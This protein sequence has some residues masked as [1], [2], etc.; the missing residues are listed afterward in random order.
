MIIYMKYIKAFNNNSDR[1]TYMKSKFVSPHLFW[2]KSNG[3][4]VHYLEEY[5]PLEYIASTSTGMQYIDL[6]IKLY[7]TL[8]TWYDIAIKYN[9]IGKGPIGISDGNNQPTLFGC[10]NQSSPWPGTFIR[11]NQESS[12]NTIG[13]FIGG[14]SKDNTLGNNNTI[15]ELQAQTAPNKNVANL[16]NSGKNK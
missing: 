15:I 1:E 9:V 7:E 12:T 10:Q 5:I 4:D 16:N 3:N 11:M 8:N 14:T 13:R 2:N 6:N